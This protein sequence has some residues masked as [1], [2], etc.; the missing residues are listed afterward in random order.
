MF[1][2][3]GGLVLSFGFR[4][5]FGFFS[6]YGYDYSDIFKLCTMSSRKPRSVGLIVGL[7]K[8]EGA[9]VNTRILH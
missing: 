7:W 2:S 1:S 3:A 9:V 8:E 4:M 6:S 5:C